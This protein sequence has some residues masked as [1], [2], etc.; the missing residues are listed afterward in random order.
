MADIVQEVSVITS[1]ITDSGS[2]VY[3]V[4]SVSIDEAKQE[5]AW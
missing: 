2:I 4:L 5:C 1:V 3:S